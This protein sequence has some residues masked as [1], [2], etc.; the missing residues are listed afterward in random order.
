METRWWLNRAYSALAEVD[1]LGQQGHVPIIRHLEQVLHCMTYLKYHV[2]KHHYCRIRIQI[3]L[4][5]LDTDL[6]I[7]NTDRNIGLDSSAKNVLSNQTKQQQY[8]KNA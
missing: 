8:L 3:I 7:M 4:E 1:G 2:R 6:F 5:M